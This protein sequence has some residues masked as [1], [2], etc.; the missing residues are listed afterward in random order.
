MRERDLEGLFRRLCTAAGAITEKLVATRAGMPD[1]LVLAPGGRV[2]LVELKTDAGDLRPVQKVW[3]ARA[4]AIG[5]PVVVLHGAA[6]IRE[7]VRI[8][9]G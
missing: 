5:H 6:E 9:L 8:T 4:A 7:W 2:Y 1:R 3:H